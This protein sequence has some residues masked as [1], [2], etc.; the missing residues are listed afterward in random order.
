MKRLALLLL[1]LLGAALLLAAPA[2]A[3][4]TVVTSTPADGTRLAT[5]PASVTIVFDESVGLGGIGYLHVTDGTGK[6]VDAGPATH[7]N[8]DA[9]ASPTAS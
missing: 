9:P 3:H 7:P 8:G 4:A 1:G 6:R 2:E 5:A